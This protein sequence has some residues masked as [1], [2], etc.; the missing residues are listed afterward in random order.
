M[1]VSSKKTVNKKESV[2]QNISNAMSKDP[3]DKDIPEE[4]S[5]TDP[6][7]NTL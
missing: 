7:T 6:V 3:S 5:E 4:V 1:D 2:Y